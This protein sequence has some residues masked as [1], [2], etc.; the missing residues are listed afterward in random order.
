MNRGI[1]AMMAK[2][3]VNRSAFLTVVFM[4][5]A[6]VAFASK[7]S[8]LLEQKAKLEAENKSLIQEKAALTAENKRLAQEVDELKNGESRLIGII[9][10]TYG[11]RDYKTTKAT[12]ETLKAKHPETQYIVECNKMLQVIAEWDKEQE[13]I[14]LENMSKLGIWTVKYYG[15]NFGNPT[16]EG[17]VTTTRPIK[18]RFSNSATTNSDLDVVLL[19]DTN[20]IGIQLWEYGSSLQKATVGYTDTYTIQVQDDNG[21][22]CELKGTNASDMVLVHGRGVLHNMLKKNKTLK[23]YMVKKGGLG[24]NES[25]YNFNIDDA[26]YYVNAVGM[27]TDDIGD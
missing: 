26:S 21:K 27:L 17:Y 6:S 22:V 8:E 2:S 3:L 4:F 16:K 13:K 23:F 12:I 24:G 9:R 5:A 14:R 25:T 11:A 7:A 19:I 20:R 15:D 18:G 10:N 1:V